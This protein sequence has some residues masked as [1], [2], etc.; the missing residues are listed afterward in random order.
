MLALICTSRS[1]MNMAAINA[2]WCVVLATQ[3]LRVIML[4]LITNISKQS[5][6]LMNVSHLKV[7][8]NIVYN[9]HCVLFI[10]GHLSSLAFTPLSYLH[11]LLSLPSIMPTAN[12]QNSI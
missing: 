5:Y 9:L 2:D 7:V 12:T 6:N 3:M 8:R 4:P 11:P 1:T 10:A